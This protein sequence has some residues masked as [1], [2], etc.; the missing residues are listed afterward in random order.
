MER[1]GSEARQYLIPG[2]P[3]T[4]DDFRDPIPP[5]HRWI[6]VKT[7]HRWRWTA[8]RRH[9]TDHTGRWKPISANGTVLFDLEKVGITRYRY[10]GAAI[11]NPWAEARHRQ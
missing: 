2:T 10:R 1:P 7:R 8:V 6:R 5:A 4:S 11:P 3:T 9:L